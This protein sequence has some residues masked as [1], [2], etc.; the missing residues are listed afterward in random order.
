VQKP[1]NSSGRGRWFNSS[2]TDP[3]A[4][5]IFYNQ[6]DNAVLMI[7]CEITVTIVLFFMSVFNVLIAAQSFLVLF[8]SLRCGLGG[9]WANLA[10][11]NEVNFCEDLIYG[12]QCIGDLCIGKR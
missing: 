7:R 2:S 3:R 10:C 6:I 5:F 11:A 9:V 12:A 1:P 4:L 8:L